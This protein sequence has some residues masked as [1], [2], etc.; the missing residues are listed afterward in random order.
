MEEHMKEQL[1]SF[2]DLQKCFEKAQRLMCILNRTTSLNKISMSFEV[3][4]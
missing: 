4:K 1:K 2:L 3:R